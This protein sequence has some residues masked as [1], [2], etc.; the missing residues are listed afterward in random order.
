MVGM[1]AGQSGVLLRIQGDVVAALEQCHTLH[2]AKGRQLLTDILAEEFGAT[3]PLRD[4]TTA[5][6]QLV[7]LVRVCCVRP[8]GLEALVAG[9]RLLQ[10]DAPEVELLTHL[11]E[12]W[13]AVRAFPGADWAA[14]R[15]AL[16]QARLADSG[17]AGEL[18]AL[19]GLARVATESR[20]QELPAHC[21]TIWDVFVYLAGANA[22]PEALPPSM[23]FLDCVANQVADPAVARLLRLW[24]R[25]WAREWKLE[26]KLDAAPWRPVPQGQDRSRPVYLVIQLDPDPLDNTQLVLSHWRQWDRAEWRPQRGED[27]HVNRSML[28]GE[29]DKIISDMEIMLGARPEAAQTGAIVLEFVLPWELLNAPVEFWPKASVLSENVPLAVDHPVV[30]RSLE[31]LRATRLHLAWHQRWGSLTNRSAFAGR[32]YWSQ[33]SGADY[34]RRLAAELSSDERIVSLVL[35]EPPDPDNEVAHREIMA[36]LRS[37]I[38]AIIWHRQDCSASEFRDA[39]N[40]MVSDG[41]L[42]HLPQRVAALRRE[43]LR[44]EPSSGGRHAG[45]HVAIL[46]D[47]PERL[48]DL[49]RLSG[50]VAEG[51]G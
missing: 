4:Q 19:A 40:A 22:A 12:E 20:V 15:A 3:L 25:G 43:A 9:M 11:C 31:R 49:P 39:V 13:H 7:E 38:P 27:K 26:D 2:D 44:M 50:D 37:G 24:N 5:R 29:V 21:R 30:V 18:R 42:I 35:S 23:V 46:W 17:A 16:L 33:P 47:D 36:A 48:P 41:G 32:A 28:E 6:T 8:G 14:L 34:F 1:L 10:P 45:W 51:A